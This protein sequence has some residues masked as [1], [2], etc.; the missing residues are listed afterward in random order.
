MTQFRYIETRD[1]I[2]LL[3]KYTEKFTQ[4]FRSYSLRPNRAYLQ[5]KYTI[6]AIINELDRRKEAEQKEKF[7]TKYESVCLSQPTVNHAPK[8][9][10]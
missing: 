7:I 9:S 2:E 10:A 3:A 5:C 1:L 6:E 8:K 4:L